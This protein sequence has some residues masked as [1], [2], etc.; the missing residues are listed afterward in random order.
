MERTIYSAVQAIG[1]GL[2]MDLQPPV[3]EV[4]EV[5][6]AGSSLWAGVPPF[7]VPNVSVGL[8]DGTRGPAHFVRGTDTRGWNRP[9]HWIIDNTNYLRFTNLGL[10]ANLSYSAKVVRRYGVGVTTC[11]SDLQVLGAGL[12]YSLQPPVGTDMV[13]RDI[14]STAWIGAGAAG[15]PN[16]NVDLDDAT[17]TARL[18][19]SSDGAQWEPELEIYINNA[20]YITITNAL[21]GA[22]TIGFIAEIIGQ[23]GVGVSRVK[24]SIVACVAGGNVDFRPP[25]GEEWKISV[26]TGSVWAGAP[27]LA[28]PDVTANLFDGTRASIIMDGNNWVLH[29]S[30]PE[31]IIDNNTYLRVTDTT[32]PAAGMNVGISAILTGQYAT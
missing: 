22:A 27:P 8:F 7:A 2:N 16:V 6:A 32:F 15:L 13:V 11:A 12:T 26:I 31:V 1:A 21:A 4:Y 25:T 14:G 9:Q 23:H 18:M 29:G 30:K 24:S 10:A 3:G 17:R 5:T 28:F 20:C 19:Q